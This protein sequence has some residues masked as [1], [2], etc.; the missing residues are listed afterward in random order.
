[1]NADNKL[2]WSIP[3]YLHFIEFFF[4]IQFFNPFKRC[5]APEERTSKVP[6]MIAGIPVG[7]FVLIAAIL[8]FL[9]LLLKRRSKR[10]QE[11]D[12]DLENRRK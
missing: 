1:M 3:R 12:E 8:I 11:D 10:E 7:L 5:F 4:R 9:I 2:K 6:G